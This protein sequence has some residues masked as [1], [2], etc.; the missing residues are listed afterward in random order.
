MKIY[1]LL[2]IG[3]YRFQNQN[4]NSEILRTIIEF[5]YGPK[6]NRNRK[7]NKMFQVVNKKNVI[8]R[9]LILTHTPFYQFKLLQISNVI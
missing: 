5:F 2:N 9:Y 4:L 3:I 6:L 8:V 1:L 7:N